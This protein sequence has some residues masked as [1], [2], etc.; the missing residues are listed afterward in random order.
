MYVLMFVHRH[1]PARSK[2]PEKGP[3]GLSGDLEP[4]VGWQWGAGHGVH[5]N[6]RLYP[7]SLS[8]CSRLSRDSLIRLVS[9]VCSL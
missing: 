1:V 9:D 4:L 5:C 3:Q 7:T 6:S 2:E 8:L